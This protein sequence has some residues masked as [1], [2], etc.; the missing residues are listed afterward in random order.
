MYTKY[1][2]Y[3]MKEQYNNQEDSFKLTTVLID[4][5]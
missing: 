4:E 2:N 3:A 1:N 5:Q